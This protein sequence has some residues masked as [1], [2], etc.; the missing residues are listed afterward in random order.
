LI[1][2]NVSKKL[3]GEMSAALAIPIGLGMG[4]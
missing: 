2:I 1:G 4:H 3:K